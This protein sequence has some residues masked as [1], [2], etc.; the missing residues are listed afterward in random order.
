MKRNRA[1]R[2]IVSFDK[3]ILLA[4][5]LLC[6]VGLIVMLDISSVQSSMMY[7]YRQGLFFLISFSIAVA[8]L[9]AFDL[10][11]LRF[12]A[13]YLVYLTLILLVFVLV[14]GS[15]IK[16]ATRQISL[17]FISFQPSFLARVALVFYFAHI[18]DK[19]HE[20]LLEATPAKFATNFAPL[21]ILTGA[22]FILIILERHLSTLIIGGATL[23]GM[24]IYAGAKKR[25]LLLILLIGI[26]G[27]V[28]VLTHGADYRKA[29]LTTYK[30]YSLFFKDRNTS[31]ADNSDYQV[32]E[33]LT[34]L[35]S[36]G[37]IGTG[38]AR[39]RAKHYYLPE[40]RTDYVFT[41]I[42]EEFGF[43][44]A[45]IVFGLHTFLFFRAFRMANSQES[46]YLK[47]LGVGL[48]MNIFCNV[49]VNTGVSM[50]ILPPTGN[51]LP[52]ISYGG[53]AL[54]IDSASLGVILNISAKRRI[55]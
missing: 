25:L 17:G 8:I 20:E 28:G 54:L 27:G 6:L 12:L 18:L 49:L 10:E 41:I 31:K 23:Y 34:A 11:K 55:V 37:W 32:K 15:T 7:F 40:A 48:A 19:R 45:I 38:I 46:Q 35:T 39:G 26:V 3:L 47:F 30:K 13:P 22:T 50:S 16:G 42:A 9:Y 36:G 44:G 21:I 5:V 51:T 2:Y 14:K 24:L 43:L 29:R 4:Y 53:S 1:Q 33:S 52:F